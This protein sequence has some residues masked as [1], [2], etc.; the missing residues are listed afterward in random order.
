MVNDVAQNVFNSSIENLNEYSNSD[1]AYNE[2]QEFFDGYDL[3]GFS[4]D[5]S[6]VL[7]NVPESVADSILTTID[8]ETGGS[9]I[10]GVSAIYE[11]DGS[12]SYFI[13]VDD[14]TKVKVD[15]NNDSTVSVERLHA[16]E[17]DGKPFETV[18]VTD[19]SSSGEVTDK[20]GFYVDSDNEVKNIVIYDGDSD[21]E[22]F[23]T[24][25]EVGF[26]SLQEAND[27]LTA[28]EDFESIEDEYPDAFA[29]NERPD[30]FH[31]TDDEG[32]DKI[33][34]I[35]QNGVFAGFTDDKEDF[36]IRE[37]TDSDHYRVTDVSGED[38]TVSKSE[39]ESICSEISSRY[40]VDDEGNISDSDGSAVSVMDVNGVLFDAEESSVLDADI[41]SNDNDDVTMETRDTKEDIDNTVSNTYNDN[42]N[43]VEVQ[44]ED[45]I[46]GKISSVK[47]ERYDDDGNLTEKTNAHK[48]EDGSIKIN[49]D[50]YDDG[51]IVANGKAYIDE[52]GNKIEKIERFDKEGNKTQVITNIYDDNGS[53]VE[54]TTD[55]YDEN[56]EYEREIEVYD[57]DAVT[58]PVIDDETLGDIITDIEDSFDVGSEI[59][60]DIDF[61]L[62]LRDE[63]SSDDNADGVDSGM[64]S[65]YND[66]DDDDNDDRDS[67]F[68]D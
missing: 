52:N 11:P 67:G 38:H 25:E 20:L 66:F 57:P 39:Y 12:R 64:E 30:F 14:D 19:Y 51:K 34:W 63:F 27:Y 60:N 36:G 46:D 37:S 40:M 3:Y 21:T 50:R 15:V 55:T 43:I 35:E 7:D 49:M 28:A 33:V 17:Y 53:L 54:K 58:E 9:G 5:L 26:D 68:I 29:D 42:G 31:M 16:G 45:Y 44:K 48:D 4:T 6:E 18:E 1:S 62:D 56:G 10:D 32:N 8:N 23:I 13:S 41:V 2:F 59:S 24:T 65:D 47:I 61:A 22:R